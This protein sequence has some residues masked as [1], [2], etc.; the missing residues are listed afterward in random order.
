[1]V[2]A[3]LGKFALASGEVALRVGAGGASIVLVSFAGWA[4]LHWRVEELGWKRTQARSQIRWSNSEFEI[5]RVPGE[6]QLRES[7][8]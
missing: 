2:A 1:M 6:P 5:D 8:Q 3:I 7:Q 4:R